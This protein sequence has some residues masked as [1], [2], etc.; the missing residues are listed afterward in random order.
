M[1]YKVVP[2][3]TSGFHVVSPTGHIVGEFT[4]DNAQKYAEAMATARYVNRQK[5]TK[6]TLFAM[7]AVHYEGSKSLLATSRAFKMHKDS[8][9]RVIAQY[10]PHLKRP[11]GRHA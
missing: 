9:R 3:T 11:K 5:L 6:R 1:N 2:F 8:I 10:Y 4:G 7:M